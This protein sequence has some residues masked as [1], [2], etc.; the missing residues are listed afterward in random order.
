MAQDHIHAKINFT[1]KAKFDSI[2]FDS[3]DI[4]FCKNE[5]NWNSVLNLQLLSEFENKSKS[6]ATLEDWAKKNG[7]TEEDLF[8]DQNISFKI[9]DFKKF[10]ENRVKNII[11]KLKT[12]VTI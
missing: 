1:D 6:D 4:D 10:I 7:K 11:K 3:K 8:V 9:V 2:G 12:I 5:D